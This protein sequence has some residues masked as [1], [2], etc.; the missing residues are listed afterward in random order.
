MIIIHLDAGHT[1]NGNPRRLYLVV[2]EGKI[3]AA[4]DEG[5]EGVGALESELGTAR[6]KAL[7]KTRVGPIA[8]TPAEYRELLKDYGVGGRRRGIAPFEKL[9]AGGKKR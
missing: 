4:V 2:E 8:T 9:R 3:L 5:H 6:G 1:T 7:A